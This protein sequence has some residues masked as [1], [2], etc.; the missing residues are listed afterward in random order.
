MNLKKIYSVLILVC[1]IYPITI[2][3]QL[4]EFNNKFFIPN[5]YNP[6]TGEVQDFYLKSNALKLEGKYLNGLKHGF[7]T[8]YFENGNVY[9]KEYFLK[10][11]LSG[12]LLEFNKD[13]ILIYKKS[14]T[15]NGFIY[16]SFYKDSKIKLVG[17]FIGE[18][19]HGKW[20]EYYK[21]GSVKSEKLYNNGFL[22]STKTKNYIDILLTDDML[23]I[24]QSELLLDNKNDIIS[25]DFNEIE[26]GEHIIYF[27]KKNQ[28]IKENY[29]NNKLNGDWIIYYESGRILIK[30][31]YIHGI[32]DSSKQTLKF[33]ES[34]NLMEEYN[35][36]INNG[37]IIKSGIFNSFYENGVNRESGYYYNDKKNGDWISHYETGEILYKI[38]YDSLKNLNPINFYYKSG[39]LFYTCYVKNSFDYYGE[40]ISYYKTGEIMEKGQYDS[41]LKDGLWTSYYDSGEILS[42]INYVDGNGIYS[43]FFITG[44]IQESGY[45]KNNMKEGSWINYY[46]NG[47]K[48]HI[49][50]YKNDKIDIN[51]ISLHY[52]EEGFLAVEKLVKE[53]GDLLINDGKYFSYYKNGSIKESGVYVD[54]FKEGL[55]R[56]FYDNG[57][58][59]SE[60]DFSNGNG[61][62]KSYYITGELLI[63]GKYI[64]NKKNGKWEEFNIEGNKY[65][66]YYYLNNKLNPNRLAFLWYNSGYKKS[67]GY[68]M[69]IEDKMVWD[70]DYIEYYENGVVYLEGEYENG[71]KNGVWKQYYPNRSVNSIK[72]YKNGEPFG[73][74][75][76]YNENGDI[77]KFENY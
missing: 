60:V 44:E 38:N 45:F 8:H 54:N 66:E 74:W 71:L 72:Y 67:E 37:N 65:R 58:I 59:K 6:F 42:Q 76:F 68:L 13:G 69:F 40:Y 70:G 50:K 43:K 4:I 2:N 11:K 49:Y 34:G 62:F 28:K 31:F 9:R 26:D 48:K 77:V 61:S 39:E 15:D 14:F 29:L 53:L 16:T 33:Y 12:D 21:N 56:E 32:L 20:I 41:N 73:K 64:N 57:N 47:N 24:K 19:M 10:G 27:D 7:F 63:K 22:D 52:D 51:E 35:E 36:T 1:C 3:S 30:R 23:K 17:E 75:T 18:Y 5:D 46:K 25:L 55:W